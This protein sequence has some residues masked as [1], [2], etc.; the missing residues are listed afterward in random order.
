MMVHHF[1]LAVHKK[2][3]PMVCALK[4][5]LSAAV[6]APNRQYWCISPKGFH[7][8]FNEIRTSLQQGADK[9]QRPVRSPHTWVTAAG[10]LG[11]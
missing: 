1:E 9:I 2:I 7:T 8:L 6:L 10:I 3:I 11:K 5:L 4:G